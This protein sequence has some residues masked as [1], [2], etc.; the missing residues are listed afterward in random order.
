MA[1]LL[2]VRPVNSAA[3]FNTLVEFPWT[4][5]RNDPYWVPPLLSMQRHKYDPQ[6]NSSWQHMTGEYFIAWRGD[7]PVGTIAAFVNH[8]YNEFHGENI[9]FFGALELYDDQL[10]ADAL[11]AQ[12]EAY[13]R[14]YGVT[15]LRGPLTFSSNEEH[16]L[17]I[18]GFD[19]PPLV[20]TPYNPPYY[21]RLIENVPGYAKAMDLYSWYLTLHGTAQSDKLMRI[22]RVIDKNNARRG[23]TVRQL[24]RK[25]LAEDFNTLKEIYNSAWEHNWGFVPFSDAE[26]DELVADLGTY[27]D[28]DLIIF[29]E[30]KGQPAGFLLGVPDI[31]QALHR[32][33][34]RP[35]KPEIITKLQTLWHWK[36]RPKISRIR[37]PFMG[38]KAQFR[39]I[40]VEGAMFRDIYTRMLAFSP[41]RGWQYADGGW[42]LETNDAM[43]KLCEE[44]NGRVYKRFR[45]Y[46]KTL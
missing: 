1:E 22:Y 11:L 3:D 21:Q 27:V 46:Q 45:V 33:Y 42:V 6:Q 19:D 9:G 30:V 18:E 7:Q 4:L 26:L 20:V 25:R 2:S 39:G 31:Y 35:G 29:A 44:H 38:V 14:D 36:L 13:L 43:N 16:G 15:A 34:A 37:I 28:H 23:I 41:K 24:N 40:G 10:V 12:A 17:L 32:A 8:R 5:Y